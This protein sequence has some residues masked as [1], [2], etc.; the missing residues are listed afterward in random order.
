MARPKEANDASAGAANGRRRIVATYDYTDER[1]TLLYQVVRYDPKDFRQRRPDGKGGW[2][3][4]LG[5]V[6]RVLYRLPQLVESAADGRPVFIVEGEKDADNLAGLGLVATT[7]AMGAGKW[8]PEYGEALAGRSVVILPDNDEPG[9]AHAEAVLRALEP[10]AA[11]VKVLRLAGLPPKG[12]VS[13]WLAAGGTKEEL[14]TLALRMECDDTAPPGDSPPADR[15]QAPEE[16]EWPRP[17]AAEAFHG[18][19]GATVREIEPHSEA[20]PVA[21]LAQLLISFGN[22]VGRTAHFR[23][24]GD[25]HYLNLFG[26]LVGRTSAGRKGTSWGRIRQVLEGVEPEWLAKRVQGGLASGE[27]MVHAVRDEVRGKNPIKGK[28]GRI[29]GYQEIIADHGEPD[30]RLLCVEEEYAGVLRMLERQGNS[31]SARIRDAWAG[32]PIG[33]LTKHS[34]T[35]CREPHISIIAHTTAEE[36]RRYLTTTEIGNGFGNRHLWFC[37]KRS[38][39]LPDGGRWMPGQQL[40]RRW[41]AAADHAVRVGEL[42][43]DAGAREVW[44]A[45]YPELSE[46][47]PGLVGCMLGRAV[48]QV[49]RIACLYAALDLAREVRAEHLAAALA[50]WDFCE[51]SVRFV[52]GDSLGDP[53]ADEIDRALRQTPAGLTREAIRDLFGRHRSAAD[54]GRALGLLLECGRADRRQEAT[55][56]RPAERWFSVRRGARKAT[57]AR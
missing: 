39:A 3:W 31:L 52:L 30:K 41:Q 22:R 16:P 44:H 9:R 11:S 27:G 50:L 38:K 34:P 4:S 51:Q 17:L 54:V 33:S 12:D 15:D 19:A 53:L 48:P 47:K 40:I 28:G 32:K 43:R 57:K 1:G 10:V 6:R 42:Q 25:T 13:D 7:C 23:A 8:R 2:T 29:E 5:D 55:G 37:V 49:M 21:L 46:G 18:L 14:L 45:V 36:I 20:D 35:K 24:E 56:G 26:V